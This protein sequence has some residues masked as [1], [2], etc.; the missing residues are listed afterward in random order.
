MSAGNWDKWFAGRKWRI[1]KE[2]SGT[3]KVTRNNVTVKFRNGKFELAAPGVYVSP[4]SQNKARRGVLLQEVDVFSLQDIPGSLYP[5]GEP[6]VAEARKTF[7]AI[8]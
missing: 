1:A 2:I 6:V 3:T 4:L 7:D 8:V 5:F